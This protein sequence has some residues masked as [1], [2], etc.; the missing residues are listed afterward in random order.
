MAAD[1]MT[2]PGA[3][4]DAATAEPAVAVAGLCKRFGSVTALDHVS[5]DIQAG[6]FFSLLGPSGCGKTTFLR[7]LGGL[8]VP[9]AGTVRIAGRDV[10]D[11]PAHARPTNTVFQSYALFPHLTAQDN[12]AFGLRMKG[13][14]AAETRQRVARVMDLVQIA[15]CAG[16]KPAQL[17]GGQKQRVALARAIV[18]EPRVLLLDEPLAALDRK[19]RAALQ[20]ELLELQHRLG[21]TFIFVTHD[22]EEALVMSDRIAV[23][24]AGRIEQLGRGAALYERPRTRFVAQF[25]G[26]CNLLEGECARRDGGALRVRT[27]FGELDV[28]AAGA[29]AAAAVAGAPLTLAIRPEQVHVRRAG[30]GPNGFPARVREVIY[31]GAATHY[32]LAAAGTLFTAEVMNT[33]PAAERFAAGAACVVHLPP[34]ALI[35]LED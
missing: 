12:I 9:D 30:G 14:A 7:V 6:E 16:R 15:D 3:R 4:G 10:R 24:N 8:E 34:A 19:L 28:P 35:I 26:T 2:Q 11:L 27:R 23:M 17:S 13:V 29:R 20:L 33:G 31:T 18:N 1:D 25:L 22:Q 21:I 32:Q 5:L